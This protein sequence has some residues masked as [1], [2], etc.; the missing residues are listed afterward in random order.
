M[1]LNPP[2]D[3]WMDTT[4][5]PD[6]V[7]DLPGSYDTLTNLASEGVLDLNMGT[8]WNGWNDFW[9]GDIK[10]VNRQVDTTQNG[11]KIT[12]VTTID[13]EQRVKQR[14]AGIRTALVPNTI[15]NQL[16]DR[17]TSVGFVPFI[18]AKDIE[19]TAK[20]LK[21]NSRFFAFF[22]SDCCI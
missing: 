3:E 12:T 4:K 20:G 5:K 21:P 8:V 15:K 19:F 7:V 1:E 22:D 17:V 16:G 2:I 14:R 10:E 9:A 6:L 13:T 11:N 18:R